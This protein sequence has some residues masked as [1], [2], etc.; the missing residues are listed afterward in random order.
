MRNEEHRD[1]SAS[2][3]GPGAESRERGDQ[4]PEYAAVGC[5]K[6]TM[7]ISYDVVK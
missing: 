6:N 7:H 4:R 1:L 5:E 2:Q 3:E